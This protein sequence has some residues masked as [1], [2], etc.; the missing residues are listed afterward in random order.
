MSLNELSQ[1]FAPQT[2]DTAMGRI[3]FR[4]AGPEAAGEGAPA[5]PPLVLL[6][7]IGSGS[8]SWVRQLEAF[9]GTRQVL[10]WDAPGYGQSEALPMAEPSAE[11]Y[12]TRLWAWLDALSVQAPVTLVGHSLGALMAAAASLQ[13]PARVGRLVLLSPAQGYGKADAE[14]REAKRRDRLANLHTLGP[15]GMAQKRGA[16]MLSPEA[17]T[18][19][20]DFVKVTMAQV[21][22][23]GYTQATHMLAGGDLPGLLARLRP[24]DSAADSMA[25]SLAVVAS[26]SADTITPPA[27]CEA[28]ARGAGLPYVS[29]GPVGHVC[30]LEA[31][32][33]VNA[34]LQ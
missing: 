13:Q 6:H 2:I 11:D 22:P 3:G 8:G 23:A 14:V 20:V 32:D 25:V 5:L 17:P 1:R 10:A 12:A 31:A 27:G 21:I 26:G 29:L 24:A 7:G 28:L 34:L 4:R 16:A 19:M 9:A 15:T 30:A 18:E 33:R